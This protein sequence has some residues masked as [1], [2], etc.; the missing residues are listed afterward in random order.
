MTK[1]GKKRN[2]KSQRNLLKMFKKPRKV[3]LEA[4]NPPGF[5]NSS[6]LVRYSEGVSSVNVG[7]PESN[8]STVG[9]SDSISPSS[10][11]VVDN[12]EVNS[13]LLVNALHVNLPVTVANAPDSAPSSAPLYWC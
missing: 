12:S 3:V 8:P 2:A 9:D 1:T 10:V 13:L 5:C 4:G 7:Y 6:S 11:T